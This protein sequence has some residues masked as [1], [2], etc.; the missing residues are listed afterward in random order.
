MKIGFGV[1]AKYSFLG[2]TGVGS[3]QYVKKMA[4]SQCY[5]YSI[6]LEEENDMKDFRDEKGK[7]RKEKRENV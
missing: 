2:C 1:E 4:Q 6:G 7:R 5:K 3:T